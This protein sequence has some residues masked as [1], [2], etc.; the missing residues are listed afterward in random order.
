MMPAL[1]K[2]PRD[3]PFS[4]RSDRADHTFRGVSVDTLE[5]VI[6]V[7]KMPAFRRLLSA[8]VF[9]EL[10]WSIGSLALAL[11][12]YRRTGSAL[13]AMAFY[14]CSQFVPAL[15]S[16]ALV[17]RLDQRATGR[18]LPA[19]YALEGLLFLV[20]AWV[21]GRFSLVPVLALTLADGLL[22]L[23]AR[24]LAR[25]ATVVVISPAGLL[26]EGNALTNGAFSIC[27]M[28][29]PAL[30]GLIVAAGGTSAALLTNSGLFALIALTLATAVGLPGSSAEA[31]PTADR[32][33]A[34]L[35]HVRQH[36]AIRV[37]LS[38]QAAALVFFTISI[39][40]EVV[41]VQHS[42]HAG[43]GGL[44]ALLSAWGAGAVLGS[45]TY[46]RWRRLPGRALISLGAG[47]LGIG[48]I[49]MAVAPSLAVAVIGA[50]AGGA[51]NGIEAIAVHTELQEHTEPRWMALTMSLNESLTQAIPG[52]GIALGGTLAALAGPRVALAVAGVGAL[53]ITLAAWTVLRPWAP[54]HDRGQPPHDGG[55]DQPPHSAV[56]ECSPS[57]AAAS[58]RR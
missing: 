49:V 31:T 7:L 6:Q 52:V 14:L 26:R 32:L 50:A 19:L 20:L 27:Y 58:G 24:A 45:A 35:A 2:P 53:A 3:G 47:A 46:A 48:F 55:A 25:A 37:L 15:F 10:A 4:G 39:P 41:L 8:Y 23:S 38:L 44:G 40:V 42:L 16:P 56:A 13:G 33:R 11:L 9:N 18:I 1:I 28:L 5:A 21:A 54:S 34:G 43:P 12:V 36:P 17:T 57:P 22:A 29:G 51:G 30:G